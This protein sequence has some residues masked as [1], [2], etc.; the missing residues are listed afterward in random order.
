LGE[1]QKQFLF[2]IGNSK[3]LKSMTRFPKDLQLSRRF[4]SHELVHAC[5]A[6][7]LVAGDH[8][9]VSRTSPEGIQSDHLSDRG[10]SE[11]DIHDITQVDE[12]AKVWRET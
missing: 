9:G 11:L 2:R 4:V 12:L 8:Q 6:E 1:S 10:G 7:E 3:P 5:H